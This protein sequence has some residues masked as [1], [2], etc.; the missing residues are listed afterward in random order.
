MKFKI[1][2]EVKKYPEHFGIFNYKFRPDGTLDVFE[3]VTLWERNLTVL[4]F[5]FGKVDG[6]FLCDNNYLV[7]LEGAPYEVGD[8][9]CHHNKLTSLEYAPEIV[10][11][12]FFLRYE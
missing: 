9:Y 5:K 11:G 1:V 8:F 7:S 10:N 4:P 2:E 12:D 6:Y 3:N